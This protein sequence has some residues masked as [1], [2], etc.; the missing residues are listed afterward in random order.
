MNILV[1]GFG[2]V[3]KATY[4]LNNKDINIFV[5]DINPSLCD[6]LGLVL[7]EAVKQADLIFISLPTPL[8]IDGTCY[9]KLID[10]L[11]IKITHDYIIIRSTIPVGYCDS[12]NVFAMPEFLTEA[13]WKNDFINNKHWIFGIYDNCQ[14]DIKNIFIDRINKLFSLAYENKSINYNDIIFCTNKEAELNLLIKNTFLSTKVSYFNEIYD[15][16]KKL[17]INYNKVID[18]VKSDDRIGLTH[19]SCPSYDGKRGYGGTC[20]PKDTNSMYYQMVENGIDTYLFEANLYRNENIDRPERDWLSDKGRTNITTNKFNIILVTGG[21]GFLGRNLCAKLLEDPTNKIICLD[22]LITGKKSNI[23]EFISNPNFKFLQ[24][25]ITKKLFLPKVDLIYHLASLASPDKYKAYPIE[26]IMVNFLG[27]KNV[28]DLARVHNAKVL[29][30]STSEV[31]GDPLIHPQPEEYYGNVNTIGERS[32]YDESKRLA[33]TIMYE[34]RK[35]YNL[36]TKIVRLFNT[37]GPYMDEKDGRVITN[38]IYKIKNNEPVEIYG[39]G[40][41]TRS[42]CYVDDLI[43]GLVKMMESTEPGPINLGNPNCEFTL[44]ELVKLLEKITKKEIKINYLPST[45][46]DPKCRKPII[47]KAN[48]KLNW[49][50]QIMLEE[51][52]TYML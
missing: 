21:A 4:L 31:Y 19:M 41:Q 36:D 1:I 33:E 46:N 16:A 45:E 14:I 47:D 5:Y 9:T 48:Q 52:L 17:N 3:G 18:L 49:Y 30:T 28:L 22:N 29:L 34:Y 13:N 25:D 51:G 43:D 12:K 7:E 40:E 27:T 2:F 24:F 32:C 23:D 8:N 11:L 35:Q 42:F 37:Y 38:F 15:L 10:D 50:P 44:N 6:P 20:F 39:N 26:T